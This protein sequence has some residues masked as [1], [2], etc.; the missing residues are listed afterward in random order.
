MTS[1][2]LA[3]GDTKIKSWHDDWGMTVRGIYF[4]TGQEGTADAAWSWS[5][6]RTAR[7]RSPLTVWS[8]LA[9]FASRTPSNI[10]GDEVQ[11]MI[12]SGAERA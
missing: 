6:P 1:T 11:A 5:S 2:S 4:G 3:P 12:S 9:D 7:Y 8:N 10:S